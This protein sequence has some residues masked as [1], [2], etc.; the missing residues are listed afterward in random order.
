MAQRAR[1]IFGLAMLQQDR[2]DVRMPAQDLDQ[3]GSAVAAK[4]DDTDGRGHKSIFTT[5]NWRRPRR[6]PRGM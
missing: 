2:L 4:A 1:T 6:D 5:V 3:L